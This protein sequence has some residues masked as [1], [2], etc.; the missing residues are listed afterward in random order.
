MPRDLR[1]RP[2]RRSGRLTLTESH[3]WD[4]PDAILPA[5]ACGWPAILSSLKSL[6]GNRQAAGD[7]MEPP[8]EMIEAIR[9]AESATPD[10]PV[11]QA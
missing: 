7:E 3:S 5:A 1:H 10:S 8:T 6:L 11:R 4:V 9:Q 2:G